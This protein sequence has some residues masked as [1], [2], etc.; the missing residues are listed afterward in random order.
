MV[1]QKME[2]SQEG[3][4]EAGGKERSCTNKGEI[5]GA[6]DWVVQPHGEGGLVVATMH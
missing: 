4:K 2:N 3:E 6:E 1:A 5:V